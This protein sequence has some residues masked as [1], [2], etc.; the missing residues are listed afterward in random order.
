MSN[1]SQMINRIADEMGRS[2]LEGQ[3]KKA[4]HTAICFYEKQSLCFNEKQVTLKHNKSKEAVDLPKDLLKIKYIEAI[5]YN[6]NYILSKKNHSDF[7]TGFGYP[8]SYSMHEN[9]IR[10]APVPHD[11]IHLNVSYLVKA[12]RLEN[13][14]DT[15]LWLQEGEELIR[16]HAKADLYTHILKEYQDAEAMRKWEQHLVKQYQHIAE[17]QAMRGYLHSSQ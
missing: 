13:P 2:D 6:S 16:T 7:F 1:F 5:I 12:P 4:I 17:E 10:L 8:K 15:N 9:E 14:S 3:I 11:D